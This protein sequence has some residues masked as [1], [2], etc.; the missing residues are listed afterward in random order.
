[1]KGRAKLTLLPTANA[2]KA[3]SDSASEAKAIQPLDGKSAL[4]I[5]LSVGLVA[6]SL[7]LFKRKIF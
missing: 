5:A 1:M 6:A 4:K 2:K 3:A 7:L